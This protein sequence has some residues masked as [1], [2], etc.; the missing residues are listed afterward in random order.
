MIRDV[1]GALSLK[2]FSREELEIALWKVKN[3]KVPGPT[4]LQGELLTW[5]PEEAKMS[6]LHVLNEWWDLRRVPGE[7]A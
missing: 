2:G 5:L 1:S 6:L 7:W 3:G 4:G